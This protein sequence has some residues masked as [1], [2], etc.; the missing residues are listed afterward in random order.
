LPQSKQTLSIKKCL[1]CHK[2]DS[3]SK[4]RDI[5]FETEAQ[6][7]D[8]SSDLGPLV[9][10]GRP[11]ESILYKSIVS[12]ESIR[13][14]TKVMPPKDSPHSA[15]TPSEQHVIAAWIAG[16]AVNTQQKQPPAVPPV[17]LPVEQPAA[18]PPPAA[19]L[20]EVVDF[21]MLKAEVLEKKCMGLP[22]SG[23]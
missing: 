22:Q 1:S 7:V 19:A 17:S 6:V 14:K 3:K 18:E 11:A 15:V 21:A 4:A 12:S 9:V 8:G 16:V 2:A 20:P 13:G 23:W 5:P 10:A